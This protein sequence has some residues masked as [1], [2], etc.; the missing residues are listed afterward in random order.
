MSMRGEWRCRM[1][2]G[3]VGCAVVVLGASHAS[4][5]V[6]NF[7]AYKQA[8]PAAKAVSCKVCHEDAVGKSTNL[9]TYGKAL[10]AFK[11]AGKAKTL[12]I[13]DFKA[14]ESA[15]LDKDGVPNQEEINAGTDPND[16]GSI[17]PA[18]RSTPEARTGTMP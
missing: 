13:E 1:I 17:P 10:Q 15:D 9:N 2:G 5:T 12:T 14:F 11:E 4:A 7:M 6:Q 18:A 8:Y 16:P 3:V